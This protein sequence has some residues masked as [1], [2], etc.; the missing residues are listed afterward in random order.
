MLCI[1][2]ARVNKKQDKNLIKCHICRIGAN[3]FTK[4]PEGNAVFDGRPMG[5][6]IKI[7]VVKLLLLYIITG[8]FID[9][10]PF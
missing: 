3:F 4:L 8:S 5:Y 1:V 2:Y 10:S 9:C 7:R 6:N